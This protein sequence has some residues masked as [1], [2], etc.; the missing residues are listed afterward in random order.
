MSCVTNQQ[1]TFISSEK[2][3]K[4]KI[5]KTKPNAPQHSENYKTPNIPK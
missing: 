3:K 1:H 2:S 4:N 5:L